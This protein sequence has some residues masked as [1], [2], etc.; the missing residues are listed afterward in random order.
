MACSASSVPQI[1]AM[2]GWFK[3]SQDFGFA[4]ESRDAFGIRE[5]RRR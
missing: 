5:E 2:F 1:C 4:L 3:G